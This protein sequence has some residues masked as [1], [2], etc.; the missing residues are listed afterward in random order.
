MLPAS[1]PTPRVFGPNAGSEPDAT[2]DKD[3]ALSLPAMAWPQ[4]EW[5]QGTNETLASRFARVRAHS[6]HRRPKGEALQEEWLLIE[7][8]QG[9][10]A[11]TNY[12]LSTLPEDIFERLVELAK[13]R[14]RIERD[15]HDL[16]QELGLDHFEGGRWRGLHHHATL[17]IAAYRILIIPAGY[18][19]RGAP[20]P[21]RA[22][23]SQTRSPS[24][25]VLSWP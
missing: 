6:A 2:L 19:P 5:R 11:P 3:I 18:R 10:D 4:V 24:C 23:T 8:P 21:A 12:W 16:K 14:W 13:L 7:W 9:Q 25:A 17:T 15:D 20:D 1:R 22:G